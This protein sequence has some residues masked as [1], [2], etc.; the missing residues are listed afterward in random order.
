MIK[1]VARNFDQNLVDLRVKFQENFSRT[2][3]KFCQETLQNL[4]E[5]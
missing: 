2:T 3:S 4:S 5:I 1:F